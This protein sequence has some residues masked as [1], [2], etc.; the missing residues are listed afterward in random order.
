MSATAAGQYQHGGQGHW[1]PPQPQPYPSQSAGRGTPLLIVAGVAGLVVMLLI[2]VAIGFVARGRDSVGI[3]TDASPAAPQGSSAYSMSAITNACD[4]V[5]P[6]PLTK[7]ASAPRLD[8]EHEKTSQSGK[9]GVLR[10]SV[11]Y[12]NSAG[13]KFP[14]NTAEIS[15]RA[16]VTDGSAARKYDNWKRTTA[17]LADDGS[18]VTSGEFTGVGTQGY[19]QFEAD[20]FGGIV[21]AEYVVCVWDGDVAVQVT[22]DLSREKESPAVDRDDLDTVARSQAR[23]VLDGL[24]QK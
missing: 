17:D 20:N 11:Y 18:V 7:W 1:P 21:D 5:D 19:W 2:G 16:D 12:G 3:P 24:R 9:F 6:T 15:V 8:P 4:L 13:D 10:C 22:I 23:K 14:M